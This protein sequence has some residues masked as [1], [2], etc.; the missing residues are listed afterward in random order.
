MPSMI[1]VSIGIHPFG[2]GNQDKKGFWDFNIILDCCLYFC[3]FV[4]TIIIYSK[5]MF[6]YTS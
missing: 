1:F 3:Y 4:A 5:D 2:V 6:K